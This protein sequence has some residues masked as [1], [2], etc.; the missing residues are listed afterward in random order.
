VTE[1]DRD[2]PDP[3]LTEEMR[4]ALARVRKAQAEAKAAGRW[5]TT[6]VERPDRFSGP[7]GVDKDG[8]VLASDTPEEARRAYEERR[9]AQE[10]SVAESRDPADEGS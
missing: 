10:G 9:R 4:Q 8:N 7:F 1:D 3:R 5:R 2:A 6:P